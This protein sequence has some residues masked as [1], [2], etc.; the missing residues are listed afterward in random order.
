M[1]PYSLLHH[2]RP[3]LPRLRVT[4][5]SERVLNFSW[6]HS[7]TIHFPVADQFATIIVE[8]YMY[9][10]KGTPHM[11]YWC[12]WVPYFTPCCSTMTCLQDTRKCTKWSQNDKYPQGTTCMFRFSTA[13]LRGTG[14]SWKYE[15][16]KSEMHRITSQCLGHWIVKRTMHTLRTYPRGP[17]VSSFRSTTSRFENTR[18]VYYIIPQLTTMLK[19]NR[20]KINAKN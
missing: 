5:V 11:R 4:G 15:K 3:S 9:K 7:M 8:H 17:D 6:F 16:K 10:I 19:R 12:S 14:F 1:I 13:L 20:T 2:E 18:I